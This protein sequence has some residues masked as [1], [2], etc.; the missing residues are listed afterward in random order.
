MQSAVGRGWV[1][2]LRGLGEGVL[3]LVEGARFLRRERR[4]WVLSLVPVLFSLFFVAVAAEFFEVKV[5]C[6]ETASVAKPHAPPV[7]LEGGCEN[8][9]TG[10]HGLDGRPGGGAD[11]DS[12][13]PQHRA[14]R[15]FLSPESIDQL[16]VHGPV[17][18]TDIRSQNRTWRSLSG[19]LALDFG[20]SG[21]QVCE[22][23]ADASLIEAELV[24]L[25]GGALLLGM[26]T[27]E[28]P[29]VGLFHRA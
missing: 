7:P 24:Y 14:V 10:L 6:I 9:R 11:P 22:E 16:A 26:I 25:V 1:H 28:R 2:S 12:V 27:G 8:D 5:Q 18:R 19:G 29:T 4:L 20:A 17:H 15:S 13:P 23:D 3:L 21:F